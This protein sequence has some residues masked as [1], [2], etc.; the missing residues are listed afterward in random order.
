MRWSIDGP[1]SPTSHGSRWR[2]AG[3]A[4]RRRRNT[5][6]VHHGRVVVAAQAGRDPVGIQPGRAS[7]P[8]LAGADFWAGLAHSVVVCAPDEAVVNAAA[9]RLG[10]ALD[11][12]GRSGGKA[13]GH[14]ALLALH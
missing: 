5:A 14:A 13:D 7:R 11:T 3:T 1:K 2:G 10:P 12:L 9:V 6:H 4:G 8:R